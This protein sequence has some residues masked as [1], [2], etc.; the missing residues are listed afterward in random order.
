MAKIKIAT[1]STADIPKEYRE[2]LNIAVL[3]I[4]VIVGEKEYKDGYDIT[5]QE[6]YEI[7]EAEEEIPTTSRVVPV[8]YQELYEETYKEGYSDIIITCINAK[9]SSTMQG[10]I[11]SKDLFYE[12]NPEAKDKFNIHIVDSTTYST[13]YGMAVI[14]AAKMARNGSSVEEIIEYINDWVKYVR[15]VF[16]PMNLKFVKK[17]GR[18]SAA[19][20]FVGDA[21]G[22]KPLI[23][24]ENGESKIIKKIRGDKKALSGILDIVAQ[25]R[26]EGTPY[27]LVYG[28]NKEMFEK[29]KAMCA[30]QL[31]IPPLFEYPVGC[32]I[33]VNTGP[34]MVAIIYRRKKD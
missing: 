7:L 20:A 28:N 34:D 32:V 21:L 24:F 3:P 2:S 29:F 15:P 13:A 30:E 10:A 6:F 17:S 27:T 14:E 1:D 11:M 18:V 16:V 22:L 4:T 5:P 25:E 33:S 23:T 26:E 9:G 31:D 19:A 8:L 12:D